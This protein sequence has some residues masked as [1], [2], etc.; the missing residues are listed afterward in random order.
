MKK[1]LH[2]N[3]RPAV[4]LLLVLAMLA[5]LGFM[6]T[7]FVAGAEQRLA[8]ES[9]RA[10]QDL[11]RRN[12]FSAL[13]TSLSV[14][15]AFQR[16]D[17]ALYG[18][19]QG[20]G[21]PLGFAGF[22]PEGGV[23]V[24]VK[25]R[26][27]SGFYG[28]NS[29][30]SFGLRRFFQDMGIAESRARDLSDCLQDWTDTNKA[31]RMNGAEEESYQN[32]I[33]PPNRPLRNMTEFRLIRGFAEVFF[34]GEDGEGNDLW[35]LLSG[36]VSLLGTMSNP[37]I[38]TAP[39]EVLE[40]LANRYSFDPESLLAARS[41][42]SSISGGGTVFRNAGDLGRNSFPVELGNSVSFICV[43]LRVIVLARKADAVLVVDT[44]L[45]T[46]GGNQ[47]GN[48]QFPFT[49]TQQRVNASLD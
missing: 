49:I 46:S 47:A 27:E 9:Q 38:N 34:D 29:M 41:G 30:E 6:V 26:D 40:V 36:S 10:E 18:P 8:W 16:I 19:A 48:S 1:S 21:D 20:W 28:I 37:N 32:G 4:A 43:N 39:K 15:G 44:L 5:M 45:S 7:Q 2:Q 3:R 12:A 24:S 11:L 14:L 13:E 23:E 42:A 33:A 17:G 25:L 31:A 35:R 22:V